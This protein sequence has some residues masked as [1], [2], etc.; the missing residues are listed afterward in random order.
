[1]K[2]AILSDLH[3][4]QHALSA[5]LK[6]VDNQ[7]IDELLILGDFVGYYYGVKRIMELLKNYKFQAV[8]GN[9][10]VLLSEAIDKNS[11]EELEIRYGKAHEM[12]VGSL[13]N[14]ELGFLL[15]LPEIINLEFGDFSM[16]LCHGSPWSN[17]FYIYPNAEENILSKFNNY[18][19]DFIFCGH[20]HYTAE[21]KYKNGRIINPGSV[22]QS[23]Q[24]GGQAFW[25]IIDLETK[26]YYQQT[27]SYDIR[28][29]QKEVRQFDPEK[30][31]NLEI[32]SR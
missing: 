10:E 13:T 6:E 22:G 23:R 20:T 7:K 8:K 5:V 15:N 19:Y 12:A 26:K 3:G 29:L 4:N 25:G 14:E 27:T 30:T 1:M 9:H 16:L 24:K 17:D 11:F 2:I 31:Y 21:F 18:E 28:M 32:L